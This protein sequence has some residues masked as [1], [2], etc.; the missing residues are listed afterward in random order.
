MTDHNGGNL[1]TEIKSILM[2][3]QEY[4]KRILNNKFAVEISDEYQKIKYDTVEQE[5]KS[6]IGIKSKT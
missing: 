6:R 3:F 1:I 4:F 5:S 2:L